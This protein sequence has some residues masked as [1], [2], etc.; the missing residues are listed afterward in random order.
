M[1]LN[2]T[3]RW[4]A[5]EADDERAVAQGL[6][7]EEALRRFAALWA[8]ARA[9]NPALGADWE[10]DLAADFAVARAVNGLPPAA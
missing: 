3:A 4:R 2:P 1:V 9:V 10:D 7:Y 6:T 8:H 5:F